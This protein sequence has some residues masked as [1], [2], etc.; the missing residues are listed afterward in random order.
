MEFLLFHD[1]SKLIELNLSS[2]SLGN[3]GLK[4]LLEEAYMPDLKSLVLCNNG[5]TELPDV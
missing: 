5:I 1:L 3:A 4:M 2:N